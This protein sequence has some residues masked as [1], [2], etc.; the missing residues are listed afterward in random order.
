MKIKYIYPPV[1]KQRHWPGHLLHVLS[2]V[3]GTVA[4]LGFL[5]NIAGDGPLWSIIV[6][7][8]LYTIYAMVVAPDLIEY[9]RISQTIKGIILVSFV[10]MLIEFLLAP[11]WAGIATS[12]LLCSGLVLSGAL[13]F[14]DLGRQRRNLFPFLWLLTIA[15]ARAVTGI[16]QTHGYLR[17]SFIIVAALSLTL[18]LLFA[19]ILRKDCLR[20]LRCRFH[21]R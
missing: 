6:A 1:Q 2:I 4:V 20:E 13:F 12:V 17:V 18:V 8:G 15:T 19:C 14:S 10:L 21:I 7:M 3:L 16:C 5:V 11:G 9:N